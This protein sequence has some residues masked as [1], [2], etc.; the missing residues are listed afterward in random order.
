M[1]I[2]LCTLIGQVVQGVVAKGV[3][4]LTAGG[5][6]AFSGTAEDGEAK[7]LEECHPK[8]L[9]VEMKTKGGAGY[10]VQPVACMRKR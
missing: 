4:N 2:R 3:A 6:G 10:G 5:G 9:R 7:P 1:P 8:L